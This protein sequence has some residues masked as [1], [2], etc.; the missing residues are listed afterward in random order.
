M[1]RQCGMLLIEVLVSLFI[2]AIALLGAVGMMARS[3]RNEMESY[4]RVQAL[5]LMQDMVSRINA[6]RQVATCYSA[7]ATGVVL[8]TGAAAAPV[9]A[10]GTPSPTA[11]QAA[12]A[13]A[14]LAAWNNALLGA[15]ET[16][17]GNRVGAMIGAIGCVDQI[18]ATNNIYRVTVAW[19]GLM[20]TATPGLTCGQGKFGNETL[21][22]TVSVQI[23]IANLSS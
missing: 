3:S 7:G 9:C 20:S 5:T 21:R 4:E 10:A 18:D 11:A 6:N 13:N 2:A 16:S 14:D 22:R 12:T 1:K 17:G 8:G 15:A 19:Q 23:Q